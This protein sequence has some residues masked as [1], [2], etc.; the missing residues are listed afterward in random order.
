MNGVRLHGG[1]IRYCGTFLTFSDYRLN[2]ILMAALMKRL[3]IHVFTH[4]F[5]GLG[6]V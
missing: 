5:I 4:V 6:E 1:Y 2:A 3:V